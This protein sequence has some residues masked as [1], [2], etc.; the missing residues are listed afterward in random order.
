MRIANDDVLHNLE[1][2]C[3]SN[4]EGRFY[5]TGKIPPLA[6]PFKGGGYCKK[7]KTHDHTNNTPQS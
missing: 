3:R 6:P 2:R 4:P 5:K 1:G 7:P